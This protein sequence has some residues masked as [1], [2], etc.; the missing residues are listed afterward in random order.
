MLSLRL[1]NPS[2]T[3]SAR[4]GSES[5][6]MRLSMARLGLLDRVVAEGRERLGHAANSRIS[7]QFIAVRCEVPCRTGRQM[8]PASHLSEFFTQGYA[9]FP[10][11]RANQVAWQGA[12]ARPRLR[13][14]PVPVPD[15]A[16]VR[17]DYIGATRVAT[18]DTPMGV[19]EASYHTA[20]SSLKRFLA[21]RAACCVPTACHQ[22]TR[23]RRPA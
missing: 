8:E 11:R 13:R 22:T 3:P 4:G 16:Y 17:H 10:R 19:S 14:L 5:A 9:V 20:C 7:L 21:N 1:Q 15:R 23:H 6:A 2:I 12:S 18:S